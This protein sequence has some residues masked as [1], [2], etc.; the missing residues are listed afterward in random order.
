M[1]P[2]YSKQ[3]FNKTENRALRVFYLSL[4]I[5]YKC[6]KGNIHIVRFIWF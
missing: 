5:E 2:I 4:C 6:G 1:S 3:R